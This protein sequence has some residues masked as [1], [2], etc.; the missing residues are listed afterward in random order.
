MNDL[1]KAALEYR[2]LGYSVVPVRNNKRSVREWKQYQQDFMS[3]HEIIRAFGNISTK[4]IAIVC[5]DISG[6]LEVIDTDS[7]NDLSNG[8]FDRFSEIIDQT[9]SRIHPYI[10]PSWPL[11][12]IMA[13]HILYRCPEI[14]RNTILTRAAC[15]RRL[16]VC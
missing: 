11:R 15:N 14:G 7:K 6:N 12:E 5:G 10:K 8:L 13:Y 3:E 9:T 16:N 2:A 4:G 1:I